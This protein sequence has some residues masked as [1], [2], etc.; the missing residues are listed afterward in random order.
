V[1]AAFTINTRFWP[2]GSPGDIVPRLQ[3]AIDALLP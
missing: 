3:A 2:A 1:D